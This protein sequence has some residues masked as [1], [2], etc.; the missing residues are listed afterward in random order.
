MSRGA[1]ADTDE[2]N[3]PDVFALVVREKWFIAVGTIVCALAGTL[4]AWVMPNTYQA[5]ITLAP[6][7]QGLGEDRLGGLGSTL[8]EL[9]G[10]ASLSGMTSASQMR[11]SETLATLKSNTL[12]EKFLKDNNLLPVLYPK[13]WDSSRQSWR[14]S[15]PPRKVPTLWKGARLFE[16][17]V[18]TVTDNTKTGLVT[19]TISW[20]DPQ[21]AATWANGLANLTNDYLRSKAITETE[22]HIAYLQTQVVKTNVV[23]LQQDLYALMESEIRSEMIARGSEE[24]ALKVIDPAQPPERRSSPRPILYTLAGA[25]AGFVISL[26]ALLFK[27][28]A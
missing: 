12:T 27:R 6:V 13:L 9:G 14:Q 18:E 11:R 19:L 26:L 24:Y 16:K 2:V 20:T 10:L 5:D 17:Q 7:T 28:P 23:T 1:R 8:S 4:I 15:L 21:L 25:F 22:R 3:L